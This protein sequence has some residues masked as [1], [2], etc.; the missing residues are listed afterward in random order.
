MT[1]CTQHSPQRTCGHTTHAPPFLE[2]TTH[3]HTTFADTEHPEH[4]IAHPT[5]R[6]T[7]AESKLVTPGHP[8]L[9]LSSQLRHGPG[10]SAG[11][12]WSDRHALTCRSLG[13]RS[14]ELEGERQDE[15]LGAG[16]GAPALA[17]GPARG[18]PLEPEPSP[19]RAR[20]RAKQRGA[21]RDWRRVQSGSPS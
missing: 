20:A 13:L 16:H 19:R 15:S 12:D 6:Q 10:D 18:P 8:T 21:E 17:P 4:R 1:R 9:T 14:A 7:H 3:G 2:H 5:F 11:Q